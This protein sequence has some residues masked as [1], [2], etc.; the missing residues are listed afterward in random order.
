MIGRN[1]NQFMLKNEIYSI[2]IDLSLTFCYSHFYY[3]GIL[4]IKFFQMFYRMSFNAHSRKSKQN[5]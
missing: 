1:F 5:C 2:R 4:P 3:G